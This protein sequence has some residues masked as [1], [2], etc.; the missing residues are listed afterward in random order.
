MSE[1]RK[2]LWGIQFCSQQ[3]QKWFDRRGV[4][5]T[6]ASLCC[7][8]TG[9]NVSGT[10][11]VFKPEMHKSQ[12]Q[13]N[14]GRKTRL[15]RPLSKTIP[16][17]QG[18][19]FLIF[20]VNSSISQPWVSP[21][22]LPDKPGPARPV[23]NGSESLCKC[24]QRIETLVFCWNSALHSISNLPKTICHF[25]LCSHDS[26]GKGGTLSLPP[27]CHKHNAEN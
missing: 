21:S 16:Q 20:C 13:E 12:K 8:R 19:V 9:N 10:R 27:A 22:V 25:P 6:A 18:F 5:T 7:P 15:P 23:C 17:T 14:Q 3:G 24:I 26:R 1:E 4:L 11:N 2:D